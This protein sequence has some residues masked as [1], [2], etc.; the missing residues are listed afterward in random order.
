MPRTTLWSTLV[1]AL[2]STAAT[3]RSGCNR[4]HAGVGGAQHRDAGLQRA[5]AG[6]LQVLGLGEESPYRR[7]IWR[8]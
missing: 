5:D 7:G 2:R 1:N 3:L 8:G 6:D 4:G